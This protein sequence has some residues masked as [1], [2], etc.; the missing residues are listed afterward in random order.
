M[1]LIPLIGDTRY[2]MYKNL[3]S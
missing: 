3:I 1:S 2:K